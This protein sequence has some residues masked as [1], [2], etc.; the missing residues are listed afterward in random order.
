VR[1]CACGGACTHLFSIIRFQQCK[2]T[3]EEEGLPFCSVLASPFSVMTTE[4]AIQGGIL[5]LCIVTDILDVFSGCMKFEASVL[6]C[7]GE[8]VIKAEV[9]LT[10][11][12]VL[13]FYVRGTA[14][15]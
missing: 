5:R 7:A 15:R 3:W 6:R 12:V 10:I 2:E 1:A 11:A 13:F 9:Q 14:H 4:V 8:E